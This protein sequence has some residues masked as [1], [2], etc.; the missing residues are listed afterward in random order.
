M[1]RYRLPGAGYASDLVQ[2][3][4]GYEM[5]VDGM[6]KTHRG[7]P[8]WLDNLSILLENRYKQTRRSADLDKAIA[9]QRRVLMLSP[10]GH[11]AIPGR[12]NNLG[13]F[14]HYRFEQ[15]GDLGDLSDAL[16]T[17][18]E[19]IRLNPDMPAWLETKG[20][21]LL[22]RFKTLRELS[23]IE[24]AIRVCQK[25]KDFTPEGHPGLPQRLHYLGHSYNGRFE[26]QGDLDDIHN[27]KAIKLKYRGIELE[28]KNHRNRARWLDGLAGSLLRR[29][30]R[31]ENL[32]DFTQAI[33]AQ[34]EAAEISPDFILKSTFLNNLASS[35]VHGYL[36]TGD[37]ADLNEAILVQH[38]AIQ[39]ID[40]QPNYAGRLLLMKTT[41]GSIWHF[42]IS[43][44]TC[45]Q[46]STMQLNSTRMLCG[47]PM[48]RI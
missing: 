33:S 37:M 10:K 46:I 40:T 25:A 34:Q 17:L 4:C 47:S 1:L 9:I 22:E 3:I 16:S 43:I 29:F 42:V 19:A 28:N 39:V 41:L 24:E 20:M 26:V 35:L 30:P 18:D 11:A 5:V 13:I 21:I 12:L 36:Q 48:R 2:A 8:I 7:M 23:D 6:P 31:T 44:P 14:L 45:L 27:L 15:S 32:E 38:Q